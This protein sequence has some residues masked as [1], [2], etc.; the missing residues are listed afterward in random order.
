MDRRALLALPALLAARAAAQPA[1]PARPIRIVNPFPAGSPDAMARFVAERLSP[2][3]GQPVLVESHSGAGG[4]IGA[5]LVAHA[6]PDGYLLGLSS[7]GPHA[8]APATY[9]ALRYD[10]LRDLVHLG[11]LGEFPLTLAVRADGPFADLAGF[12]AAARAQPDALRVGTVGT[13]GPGHIVTEMLRRDHGVALTM[14]PFRGGNPAAL[15][16]MGGRIE[17]VLA[18][19]GE[20]GSQDRLRLLALAAEARVPRFAA[21][22]SLRESGIDI[23]ATAWFGLCAPAGLPPGIAAR[24]EQGLGE[25]TRSEAYAAFLATLNAAPHRGLDAAA[26][27][28]FVAEEGRRWGDAARAF[29]IR[30]E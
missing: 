29:G 9:P 5:E 20:T 28:A 11:L 22:P 23:L 13:G 3:L 26:M 2:A 15:E 16:V 6:P 8:V 30:A 25:A 17:A 12:L 10:P 1:W 19:L 27:T 24:L 14:V 4:T 21:V 18:S 7:V